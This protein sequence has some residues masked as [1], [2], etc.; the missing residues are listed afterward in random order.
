MKELELMQK[1]V[2]D[3]K[4]ATHNPLKLSIA[5]VETKNEL[6]STNYCYT[7][8]RE[9]AIENLLTEENVNENADEAV[10]GDQSADSVS[11]KSISNDSNADLDR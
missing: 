11:I 7:E 3:V 9:R 1:A 2:L 6:P 4:S 10:K 5:G 8:E